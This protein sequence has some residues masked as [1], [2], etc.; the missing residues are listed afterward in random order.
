LAYI[1]VA[2]SLGLS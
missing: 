1:F 2:D